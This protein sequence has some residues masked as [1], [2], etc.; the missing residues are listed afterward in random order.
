MNVKELRGRLAAFDDDTEV[1][2]GP[3][4]IVPVVG[5]ER[6]MKAVHPLKQFKVVDLHLVGDVDAESQTTAFRR[7]VLA[8]EDPELSSA[9]LSPTR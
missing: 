9:P 6:E 5:E 2:V 7:V 1:H 8:F 3:S 4:I